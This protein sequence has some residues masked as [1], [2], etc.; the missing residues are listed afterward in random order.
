M[1]YTVINNEVVTVAW[2][3]VTDQ[4]VQGRHCRE[5]GRAVIQA[6]ISVYLR[7]SAVL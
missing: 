2:D 7:T 5:S 1:K 4:P 6:G 3:R